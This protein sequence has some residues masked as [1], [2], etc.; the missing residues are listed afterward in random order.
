MSLRPENQSGSVTQQKGNP[1]DCA[2]G[3]TLIELLA[4]IVSIALLAALLMPVLSKAKD[5]V[6]RANCISN[7][8]QLQISWHLY[9][10]DYAGTLPPND[11]M[12]VMAAEVAYQGLMSWC[13]DN[14]RTDTTS[15]AIQA[16]LLYPYNTSVAIYHCPADMSTIEDANGNPLAQPRYRSYNMSQ[17]VNGLGMLSSAYYFNMPVD[18]FSPCYQ[19]LAAITNP[20]PSQL[21]VLLDEN[22]V[23]LEDAQFSYPMTND[24][25]GYW[26]DMPA[27]RHNQGCNF[28]FADGHVE[29]W[30]WQCPETATG[31][32]QQVLS[33]QTADYVRVG[34]AMR[35]VQ[36]NGKPNVR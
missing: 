22:E 8:R 35:Q 31:R 5:E 15:A 29:Y 32:F 20:A 26:F 16:G 24:S 18:A 27:N 14:P 6:R 30:H 12:E 4:V 36:L 11:S 23:T 10:D 19:T 1:S 13:P 9:A 17:S 21:F 2:G 7:L 34:N 33:Q 3:F 28:S 25:Y